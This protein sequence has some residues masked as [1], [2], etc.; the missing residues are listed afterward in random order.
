VT[1]STTTETWHG[2]V[3]G[4]MNRKCR[5]DACRL[6]QNAYQRDRYARTKAPKVE[7]FRPTNPPTCVHC[8]RRIVGIPAGWKHTADNRQRCTNGLEAT[9]KVIA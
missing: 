3:N 4:Y 1:T 5:C 7:T 2:T 6:A 8:D 9:P